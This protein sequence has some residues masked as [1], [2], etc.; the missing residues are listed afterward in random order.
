MGFTAF[1]LCITGGYWVLQ[2]FTWVLLG[3]YRVLPGF[4]G[5]NLVLPRFIVFNG[6]NWVLSQ[7]TGFYLINRVLSV[8]CVLL[9]FTE[10]D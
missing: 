10:F 2:Y 9:G 6:H 8:F 3:F 5:F 1:Y 7:F 4:V